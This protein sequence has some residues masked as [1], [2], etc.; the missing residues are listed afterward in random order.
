MVIYSATVSNTAVLLAASEFYT[1]M[2]RANVA[3][4]RAKK[5]LVVV[6]SRNM[7]EFMP[8]S[9]AAYEALVLWKQLRR[10]CRH[11]IA[12]GSVQGHNVELYAA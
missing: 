8:V 6:A 11:P 7:V 10:I 2:N 5:R 3:M 12:Q 9:M 1:C 4:S